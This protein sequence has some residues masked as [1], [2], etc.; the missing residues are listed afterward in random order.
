MTTKPNY[1]IMPEQITQTMEDAFWEEYGKGPYENVL[2]RC[3]RAMYNAAPTYEV[4]NSIPEDRSHNF[5]CECG[6]SISKNV[7]G[8]EWECD[9]CEFTAE[10]EEDYER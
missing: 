7:G 8:G 9:T 1:K 3:Y 2:Q 4:C 5:P 6:G 10:V